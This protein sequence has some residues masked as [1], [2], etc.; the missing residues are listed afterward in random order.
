M[1]TK[2]TTEL[3]AGLSAVLRDVAEHGEESKMAL[4]MSIIKDSDKILKGLLGSNNIPAEL[5]DLTP[6][7]LAD[8]YQAVED[9][10]EGWGDPNVR[11]AVKA[12]ATAAFAA[13]EAVLR[14]K[15]VIAD[16]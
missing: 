9:S 5:A 15:V 10:L 2:E 11:E 3:V 12:T 13:S 14:W 1:D 4:L 7:E 16:K 6:E 8:L